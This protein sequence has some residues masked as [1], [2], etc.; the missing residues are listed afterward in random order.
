LAPASQVSG[1]SEAIYPGASY[2]LTLPIGLF[3]QNGNLIVDRTSYNTDNIFVASAS[4]LP[5]NV[6]LTSELLFQD[7]TGAAVTNVDPAPTAISLLS[8]PFASGQIYEQQWDSQGSNIG[9]SILF[10]SITSISA[11]PEPSTWAMMILG[12][13][14]IGFMAYRRKSKPALMAA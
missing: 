12:F 9:T 13:A 8:F 5:L 4:F 1:N 14:G 6:Y 2:S 7:P 3:S 10:F 11:V